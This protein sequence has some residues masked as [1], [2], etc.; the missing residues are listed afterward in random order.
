MCMD[1]KKTIGENKIAYI[2]INI[3]SFSVYTLK[4]L[5]HLRTAKL[6]SH[7]RLL[8]LQFYYDIVNYLNII[9][10]TLITPLSL[11]HYDLSDGCLVGS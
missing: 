8:N 1:V 3:P 9:I 7:P 6:I 5:S 10:K 4:L 11:L 2:K